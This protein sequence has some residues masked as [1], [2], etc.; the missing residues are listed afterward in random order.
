MVRSPG[1]FVLSRLAGE[2]ADFLA[3]HE[4]PAVPGD[5]R[6]G[7]LAA[8]PICLGGIFRGEPS[9]SCGAIVLSP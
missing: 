8:P 7:D 1:F 2:S 4:W 6:G 3:E 9:E 5:D